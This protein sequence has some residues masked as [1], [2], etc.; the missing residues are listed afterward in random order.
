M[1]VR[2]RLQHAGAF[3]KRLAIITIAG[4]VFRVA[5]ILAFKL[6]AVDTC[7]REL[8]GDAL[9]YSSSANVFA[10]GYGF[11]NRLGGPGHFFPAADHPP[12]TTIVMAPTNL[13]FWRHSVVAQRLG[14]AMLG[15]A[16][17]VAM[18]LLARRLAGDR[19]GLI[20]AGIAA[21]N[22][23]FWMNDVLVMSETLA[24]LLIVSTL[25]AVYRFIDEPSTRRAAVVGLVIGLAGLTRAE[26]LLF[27]PFTLLPVALL[28][29]SISVPARLGRL[30]V[31][32]LVVVGVLAPWVLYN[33]N[34]FENPVYLSTNDGITLL[35]AN[36]DQVYGVDDPG[37]VGF[38]KLQ[39]TADV[40]ATL[41]PGADESVVDKAYRDAAID[42]IKNHKRL[43]P[44]VVMIRLGRGW[45]V[46][47]PDQMAWLNQGEGRS[48]PVSWA[49][50]VVWWLLLV[51]AGAGVV[52]LFRRKVP[53]WPLLSTIL[54]VS[55]TV[56]VF[57]GIV[58]F[59]LPADV[60]AT[61][62]AAVAIDAL[63]ARRAGASATTDADADADTLVSS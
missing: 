13:F 57:Y 11:E 52:V 21:V 23:N 29:R 61:A 27:L 8:C 20:A 30:A 32:S 41:P 34:R 19:A 38:W 22:P 43:V 45:G 14:M 17:I 44:G 12:L 1:A 46:Y 54:V 63:L 40:D 42:Y 62:L 24:T 4:L 48:R 3:Q 7:D 10:H 58:R 15:A 26:L 39:C 9:Y 53:V 2:E 51:P 5:Y 25:I 31:A 60:A 33:L 55:V 18:G 47:G 36:C 35:G 6:G 28:R 16:V 50:Y 59:R 49:G 56:A 37:G